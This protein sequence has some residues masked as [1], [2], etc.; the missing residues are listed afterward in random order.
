MTNAVGGTVLRAGLP[1]T[2]CARLALLVIVMFATPVAS[3]TTTTTAFTKPINK[4]TANANISVSIN[5]PL[6]FKIVTPLDSGSVIG[7]SKQP[8]TIAIPASDFDNGDPRPTYTN[9]TPSTGRGAAPATAAQIMI[10]GGPNQSYTVTFTGWS[11]KSRTASISSPAASTAV[12][13]YF[14]TPKYTVI[15]TSAKGTLDNHG[16]ATVVIGSTI[17][18]M[19]AKGVSGE[20]EYNPTVVVAYN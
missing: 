6:G 2:V 13:L 14:H 18:M 10:T 3:A 15:G 17:T 8:E 16:N 12:S 20:V 7:G 4:A 19:L 11:L 5:P 9:L 1:G